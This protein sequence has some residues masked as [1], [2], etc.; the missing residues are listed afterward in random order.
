[1][2]VIKTEWARYVRGTLRDVEVRLSV[3]THEEAKRLLRTEVPLVGRS[4]QGISSH[5]GDRLSVPT[6]TLV[7]E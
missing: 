7:S 5:V 3:V 2:Y 4:L 1:M 6:W